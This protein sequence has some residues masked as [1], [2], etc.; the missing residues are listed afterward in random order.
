MKA[1]G[2]GESPPDISVWDRSSSCKWGRV[3]V[4][5]CPVSPPNACVWCCVLCDNKTDFDFDFDFDIVVI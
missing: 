5:V 1:G 3:S 4:C 2:I